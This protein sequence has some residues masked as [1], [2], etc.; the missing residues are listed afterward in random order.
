MA[1][2]DKLFDLLNQMR[3]NEQKQAELEEREYCIHG[4]CAVL[5]YNPERH[6]PY[7]NFKA[8]KDIFRDGNMYLD[9]PEALQALEQAMEIDGAILIDADG[10]LMHSGRYMLSDMQNVYSS[11]KEAL[12]TY[13]HLQETSDAGTR[14]I[15]AIA[16]SVQQPDL[17][18]YTLKSDYPE[19][20]VIKGGKIIR[21][22]VPGETKTKY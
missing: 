12:A 7:F 13:K 8:G 3:T 18:F 4:L 20:R 14:H 17:L 15:A 9:H 21:S 2:D 16:L 5:G 1:V 22:T 10:K 11:N 19:L 6:E